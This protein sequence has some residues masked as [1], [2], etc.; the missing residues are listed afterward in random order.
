MPD[1]NSLLVGQ[2]NPVQIHTPYFYKIQSN[3]FFF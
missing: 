2:Y 3:I 1:P